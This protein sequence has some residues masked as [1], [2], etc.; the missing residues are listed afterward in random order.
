VTIDLAAVL[1]L[2]AIFCV[3]TFSTVNIGALALV[4]SFVF[5]TLV[6]GE[7]VA[8]ITSGFPASI[9]VLLFG[10]TYLFSVASANGTT[11]YVVTSLA[12][13]VRGRAAVVP[14]LLFVVAGTATAAGAPGQAVAAIVAPLGMS[15]AA[16]FGIRPLLAGLMVVSGVCAGSFSPVTTLGI[17]ANQSAAN[18]SLPL[19]SLTLFL[20]AFAFNAMLAVVIYCLFGGF[21]LLRAKELGRL[22]GS[23][24]PSPGRPPG[25]EDIVEGTSPSSTATTVA[26]SVTSPAALDLPRA[27][28]LMAI[29]VVAIGALAFNLDIGYLAVCAAVVLHLLFPRKDATSHISWNVIL[30]I[31]GLLTFIEMLDRAGM[32]DRIGNSVAS[33]GSPFVGSLLLAGVA[34]M[35]SAFASSTATIGVVIPLSAPLLATGEVGTTGLIIA[36][37]LSA[38]VVDASPLSSTGALVVASTEE[39]RQ[40]PLYRG[41]LAWGLSM[42]VIAPLLACLIFVIPGSG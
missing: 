27:A 31:C 17:I 35:V 22:S 42:I 6:L 13:M 41:L 32:I 39:G 26:S 4:A 28:T 11:D 30:L 38:T 12:R 34:A 40:R 16:A 20:G 29:F 9:F 25:R 14:W 36:I 3:G 15:L 7:D 23:A 33:I 5:G 1:V 18:A 8:T 24:D 37:C 19:N 10:I 21:S 2:V